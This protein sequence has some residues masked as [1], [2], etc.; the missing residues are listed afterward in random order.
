[1]SYL[2][3][4]TDLK[5]FFQESK[6][7]MQNIWRLQFLAARSAAL[8]MLC[9]W[10]YV[11][12]TINFRSPSQPDIAQNA[13]IYY[14]DYGK[15]HYITKFQNIVRIYGMPLIVVLY[16]HSYLAS[17]RQNNGRIPPHFPKLG[18]FKGGWR[19]ARSARGRQH[20]ELR[21]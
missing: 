16:A 20:R 6:R 8:I 1:M 14:N 3:S 19:E 11:Q 13:S 2:R 12:F 5:P 17:I 10:L 7:L 9:V 15:I 18:V 4:Y 21:K